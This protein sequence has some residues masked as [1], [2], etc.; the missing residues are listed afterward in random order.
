MLCMRDLCSHAVSV[1]VCVCVYLS[2]T[3]VNSVE[4]AKHILKLFPPSGI[5][6]PFWF[7]VSNVLTKTDEGVTCKVL[8]S[9]DF[10]PISWFI[11]EMVQNSAMPINSRR[12]FS[13]ILRHCARYKSTYY[14]YYYRPMVYL[15]APF[16]VTYNNPKPRFQVT[17]FF[18]AEYLRNS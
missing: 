8:N 16:S 14:Y 13:H 6:K 3:F 4:T 11:S 18:D 9:C 12:I 1:C 2:V 10:R 15:T 17:L 7:S 5:A